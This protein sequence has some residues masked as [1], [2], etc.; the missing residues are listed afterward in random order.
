MVNITFQTNNFWE[1][2]DENGWGQGQWH[3][4]FPAIISVE[5]GTTLSKLF[6]QQCPDKNPDDCNI[7]FKDSTGNYKDMI[8]GNAILEEGDFVSIILPILS[9]VYKSKEA[10][11][12]STKL[13]Y[14]MM[15]PHLLKELAAYKGD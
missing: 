12:R 2:D 6:V 8:G 13:F 11:L 1:N 5:S 7:K 9:G 4:T 3:H 10:S 14:D 15:V